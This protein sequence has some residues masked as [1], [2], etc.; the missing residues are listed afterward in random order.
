MSRRQLLRDICESG[1]PLEKVSKIGL[2][3]VPGKTGHFENKVQSVKLEEVCG[4]AEASQETLE[5]ETEVSPLDENK[6]LSEDAGLVLDPIT[7][8]EVLDGIESSDDIVDETSGDKEE[9]SLSLD[10]IP[11][12]KTK[13]PKKVKQNPYLN[14]LKQDKEEE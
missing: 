13:K 5:S 6:L 9:T 14:T 11:L 1:L 7:I 4:S 8:E 12:K 10:A 2:K 3:H